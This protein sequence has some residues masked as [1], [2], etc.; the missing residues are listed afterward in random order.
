MP[1]ILPL[2]VDD[3]RLLG[4]H[5]DVFISLEKTKFVHT[6]PVLA[7]LLQGLVSLKVTLAV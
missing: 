4:T 1:S 2:L 3:F 5:L 7:L 6:L